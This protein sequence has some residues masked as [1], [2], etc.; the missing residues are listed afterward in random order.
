MKNNIIIYLIMF[1]LFLFDQVKT[2]VILNETCL[3]NASKILKYAKI[4]NLS[5]IGLYITD[6]NKYSDIILS[7]NA[8]YDV[9]DIDEVFLMPRKTILPR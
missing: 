3:Q 8:F 9:S 6:F 7:C 4:Y 1:T 5:T 2:R